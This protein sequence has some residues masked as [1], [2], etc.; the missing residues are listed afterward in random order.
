[1][2]FRGSLLQAQFTAAQLITQRDKVFITAAFLSLYLSLFF[3]VRVAF[4]SANAEPPLRSA[5]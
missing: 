5:L 2:N 3:F 4:V 1:M